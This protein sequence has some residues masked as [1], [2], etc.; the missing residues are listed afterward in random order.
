MRNTFILYFTQFALLALLMQGTDGLE[1]LETSTDFIDFAESSAQQMQEDGDVLVGGGD[2]QEYVEDEVSPLQNTLH[3]VRDEV[4]QL[5][6]DLEPLLE[7]LPVIVEGTP[8]PNVA[9]QAFVAQQGQLM[10]QG[11]AGSVPV[12]VPVKSGVAPPPPRVRPTKP[13]VA[14]KFPVP[15]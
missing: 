10:V 4:L 6:R 7:S 8:R 14:A 1:T 11:V 9:A 15:P 12:S 3:E 5:R 13:A 2:V